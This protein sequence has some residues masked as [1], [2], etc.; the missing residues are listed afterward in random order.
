MRSGVIRLFRFAGIDV[1]LHFSWFL[2]AA[3]FMTDYMRRL[4]IASLGR[5][6]IRRAICHRADS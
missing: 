2:V 4:P 1:F 6:R 5:A 3:I